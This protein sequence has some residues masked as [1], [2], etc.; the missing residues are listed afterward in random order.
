MISDSMA[1]LC[2]LELLLSLNLSH[3]SFRFIDDSHFKKDVILD[4]VS[5]IG[6][7]SEMVGQTIGLSYSTNSSIENIYC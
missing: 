4:Y 6:K 1:D 3:V 7:T 2:T 5:W